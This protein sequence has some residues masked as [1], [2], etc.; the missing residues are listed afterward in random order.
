MMST[1][2]VSH[3]LANRTESDRLP[4][5]I[6]NH[7][8]GDFRDSFNRLPFIISHN[9]AEHP[10][11]ELPRL[12]ELAKTLWAKTGRIVFFT[13]SPELDQGWNRSKH[14]HAS[15]VRAFSNIEE[16]NSWILLKAIQEDP[17][18][19]MVLT[20]CLTEL[21]ELT[22][23]PLH[24]EIT[25]MD[26]YVF[27]ASP[28]T[29]TPYHI[30]HES[31]FLLQI[32]GEKEVNLFDPSDPFVLTDREIE[33]YYVG[34]LSAATYKRETQGKAKVFRISAGQGV[35]HP[36]RAPHWV[37]NGDDYS[38]ALSVLFFMR[39]FDLES[40]VYQANHYIRK[41]KM[42]PTPPGKSP[43][44]DNVKIFFLGN[45]GHKANNKSDVI[46]FGLRKYSPVIKLGQWAARRFSA[47]G[48]ISPDRG[49]S[50]SPPVHGSGRR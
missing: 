27:I 1:T 16:T 49:P 25:W 45:L 46:R 38:V 3:V 15:L 12:L 43:L 50:Q 14:R 37:R 19:Q 5:K 13:D 35:H 10:L 9:L 44:K 34:D 39:E 33:Q 47:A 8:S 11:F 36:V 41:L 28:H 22:G 31:N 40:R 6:F 18:Y 24:K 4:K 21:E 32:H 48:R 20:K 26:A 30:D 7:A 2:G 29:V 17:E 23:V 42:T